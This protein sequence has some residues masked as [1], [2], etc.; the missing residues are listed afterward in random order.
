VDSTVSGGG[1][2]RRFAA[3]VVTVLL[4]AVALWLLAPSPVDSVAYAPPA[5]PALRGALAPNTALRHSRRIAEGRLLGSEDVAVDADGRLFTGTADG[6]VMRVTPGADGNDR[7]EVFAETGGRPLGVRLRAATA[8]T[9]WSL[10]VAD[11]KKGLLAVDAAGGVKPLATTAG[12]VPFGFTNDL[13][14]AADGRIYFSDSSTR[15]GIDRY[16]Y[17][18]L[19]SRP[20]G[21]FLVYD[22]AKGEAKVLLDGLF[23]ANGVALARGEDFVLVAETYRYRIRRYW[24]K[25]ARAGTSELFAD[26]LPGFPDN[27]STDRGNG[28]FWVAL[29]T[30][31][32]AIMDGL[33]PHP[34]LKEQLAKLPGFLWPKPKPYGL[35]LE[36]DETGRILRSLHDPG[37]RRVR[38]V[39]SA[40]PHG[41]GLY[42]GSL[43]EGITFWP[44]TRGPMLQSH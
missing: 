23:F 20:H 25:G 41:G 28:H 4:L 2:L 15:F 18:L 43:D 9:P 37:G 7:L 36:M 42:L 27:L 1:R 32:N 30:V 24:L 13:D 31:R 17:D 16:L 33:H 11:A 22:P 8:A 10:F 39:T 38:G 5:G 19:E 21:R 35:V 44:G 40:A 12:G 34:W 3:A 14:V 29:F 6:R 26:D